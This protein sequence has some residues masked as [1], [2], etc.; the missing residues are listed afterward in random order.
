MNDNKLMNRAADNIRILAASM[1]EK[2]NSGHPG[3]AMGGADFVNVL[4]SEFL[5]YDPENP[6]WEGRDRFF[7][8]PGHMSP[9]LYSQ[10]ALAGKFTLDELKESLKQQMQLRAF[11]QAEEAY[12]QSLINQA[13]ANSKVDIPQEMVDQRIDEIEQE[14]KLNMEAQGMDFDK[15]LSNMGK[16]EEEFRQSYNKT[17]EQQVR[18]GLVLA[19]IANVEKLEATNQDLNMEVYSMARQFNAEPKDVIKIIRDENR[20]GMLYNS[21]LRK[22]AAAFIY[23]AAVKEESKKEE[24][25]KKTEAPAKEKK[26]SPLAAKTVK[27]LKAYAEE[28]GIAL[29]SRAKKADIIATIEAAERK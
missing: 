15:Y 17:A 24:T 14:V 2:A 19:E 10:L 25:A 7:L 27:E 1:V 26:E 3:G 18:E 28:K 5:V 20:A 16:S 13:V 9:M 8:D 4:F 23:G 6:A 11:Q 29:D 21:V 22:K 12:H